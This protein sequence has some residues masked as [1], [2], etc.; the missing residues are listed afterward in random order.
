VEGNIFSKAVTPML[1]YD[2]MTATVVAVFML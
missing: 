2:L 1:I